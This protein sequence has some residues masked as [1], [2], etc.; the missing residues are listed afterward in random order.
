MA[1]PKEAGEQADRLIAD[2]NQPETSSVVE[3][4]GAQAV[5]IPEPAGETA[6][7]SD[8]NAPVEHTSAVVSPDLAA[9]QSELAAANQR[10]MVL[11]GMISKKDGEIEQMRGILATLSQAKTADPAP[12]KAAS[13]GSVT[14]DEV[15]EFGQDLIDLIARIAN[16]VVQ[17]NI[18]QISA[19]IDTVQASLKGVGDMTARTQTT[20]FEDA[21]TDR[22]PDWET[23]NLDPA[24]MLSLQE[25]DDYSGV[26]KIDLLND[27]YASQDLNRTALFFER[28]KPSAPAPVVAA[29]PAAK[30]PDPL[31]KLITPASSRGA[32]QTGNPVVESKVWTPADIS[33]LYSDQRNGV[34]TAEEFAK[35]EKDLYKAQ[36]ENRIAA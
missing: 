17:S 26:K 25:V 28:F 27:A 33:K 24:F 9:V 5:T 22:V 35:L 20:L 31:I 30:V 19:R 12:V 14:K 7:K 23:I 15:D 13:D 32:P 2:L 4:Q 36:S 10:W 18:A 6:V 29:K 34:I 8:V 1:H 11:Q 3:D 16:N 21:L